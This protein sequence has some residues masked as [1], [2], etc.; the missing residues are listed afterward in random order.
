MMIRNALIIPLLLATVTMSAQSA[1]VFGRRDIESH[2]SRTLD[3]AHVVAFGE[4]GPGCMCMVVDSRVPQMTIGRW[5]NTPGRAKIIYHDRVAPMDES[6]MRV[7]SAAFPV[8]V[9]GPAELT[10]YCPAG[11]FMRFVEERE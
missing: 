10:L 9:N 6:R 11:S 1:T 8:I 7:L 2:D 3:A 5:F 4:I